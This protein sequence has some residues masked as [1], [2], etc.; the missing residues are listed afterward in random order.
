[1]HGLCFQNSI[2][3]ANLYGGFPGG[4]AVENLLAKKETHVRSLTQEDFLEKEK[5]THFSIVTWEI[6]WAKRRL[7]GYSP[8]GHKKSDTT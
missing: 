4:S 2:W 1:M 5:A 6:Q 7:A 8:R 3:P